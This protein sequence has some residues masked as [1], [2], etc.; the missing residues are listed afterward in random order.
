[1]KSKKEH[2]YITTEVKAV[3]IY[4]SI[5]YGGR[6]KEIEVQNKV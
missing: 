3:Y 5:P 1:M 2:V 6:D 4:L